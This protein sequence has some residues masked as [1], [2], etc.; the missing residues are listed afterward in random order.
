M[1][2]SLYVIV[3]VGGERVALRAAEIDSVIEVETITPVPLAPSHVAGLAALRS[4]VL[5]IIDPNVMLG[6]PPVCPA[7]AHTALVCSFEGH[8]YGLLVDA[9]EDVVELGP[10]NV[11]PL[12]TPVAS[13]WSPVAGGLA[14]LSGDTLL[15]ADVSALLRGPEALAA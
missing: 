7:P 11:A 1:I 10:E 9:V 12:T 3:R 2:D 5:T 13:N 15:I 6:L 4:R 8:F 14:T